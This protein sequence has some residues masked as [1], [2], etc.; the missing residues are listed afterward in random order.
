[1]PWERMPLHEGTVKMVELPRNWWRHGVVE[2]SASTY[3]DHDV[4]DDDLENSVPGSVSTSD[5]DWDGGGDS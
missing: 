2:P 4:R 5:G 1:M 3:I